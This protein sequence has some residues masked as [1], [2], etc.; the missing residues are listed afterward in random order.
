MRARVAAFF[1]N[2]A[3]QLLV[4]S[5]GIAAVLLGCGYQWAAGAPAHYPVVS[6]AALGLAL[7]LYYLVPQLPRRTQS[8]LLWG[9]ALILLATALLGVDVGSAR[10]WIGVGPVALQGSL[11]LLPAMLV[12]YAR[13]NDPISSGAMVLAA[14]ALSLQPDRAMGSVLALVLIYLAFLD[15]RPVA[16]ATALLAAIA[17]LL[18][19][20]Q[21][22][23]LVPVRFVE[24]VLA[25]GFRYH[26]LLGLAMGAALLAALL[27]GG[28]S[29]AGQVFGLCW[30]LIILASVL[31]AYPSP[32]I[33]FGVSAI[34][35]YWLSLA[36]VK[37]F[38]EED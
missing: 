32:L 27:A 22:D 12:I 3:R 16:L 6:L 29:R 7:A 38:S 18:G 5:G 37:A 11:L 35:G 2:S 17:A 31:G 15:R 20:L 14:A 26:V 33:G 1:G 4:P 36:V 34:F 28:G 30:A 9:G 8:L 25:D 10:R 21:P 19:W 23:T 13:Q 24:A